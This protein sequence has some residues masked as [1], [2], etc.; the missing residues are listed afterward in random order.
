MKTVIINNLD[1]AYT[2]D[3]YGMFNGGEDLEHYER[4]YYQDEYNLTDEE[5]DSLEFDY[6]HPAVVR[7]FAE[8][9]VNILHNE[10]VE[11]DGI[12]RSI[13]LETSTSPRFYNYTTDSYRATWTVDD[14]KLLEYV[15][16]H[17]DEFH[18]FASDEW[19][20]LEIFNLDDD[21]CIENDDLLVAMIDFYTRNTLEAD[22]YSMQMW[23]RESEVWVN[24]MRL[25]EASQK[26][27]DSKDLAL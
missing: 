27:I 6:N 22:D 26:L 10:L 17:Y 20:S 13:D 1:L 3:T 15:R 23:E 18:K 8:N 14:V 21:T 9:S 25:D 11:D 2:I 19:S 4:E 24:G 12:I 7:Q 16:E 5:R